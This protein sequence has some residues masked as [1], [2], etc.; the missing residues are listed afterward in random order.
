MDKSN[1]SAKRRLAL[2]LLESW[3]KIDQPKRERHLLVSRV[4]G[5]GAEVVIAMAVW[6]EAAGPLK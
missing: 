6:I 4:S 3:T 5:T 2:S 1:L